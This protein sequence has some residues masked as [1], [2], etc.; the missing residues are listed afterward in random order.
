MLKAIINYI[1]F[2]YFFFQ[3]QAAGKNGIA[4]NQILEIRFYNS[5]F[6]R[7]VSLKKYIY[8]GSF[9]WILFLICFFNSEKYFVCTNVHYTLFLSKFKNSSSK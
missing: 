5:K 1:V 2:G 4:Q 6:K 7:I 8:L 3:F 9:D